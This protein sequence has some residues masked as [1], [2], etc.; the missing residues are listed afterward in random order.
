VHDYRRGGAK[1]IQELTQAYQE[2]CT[3]YQVALGKMRL[4]MRDVLAKT[5]HRINKGV[6]QLK[7]N[8]VATA[9]KDWS[10]RQKALLGQLMEAAHSVSE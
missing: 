9:K 2:D 7:E 8:N 3:A 5:R 6:K 1:L 10:D 4:V